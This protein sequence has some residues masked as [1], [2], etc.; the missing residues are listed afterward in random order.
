[1]PA[2]R[3]LG[4]R[5]PVAR[6]GIA[7]EAARALIAWLRQ[8]PVQAVIAHIHPRHHA[9]AAVAAAAGLTPTGQIQDGEIRWRLTITP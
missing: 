4:G 3:A 1:M 9:S 8:Q 5:N 7:S 2:G 6:Q